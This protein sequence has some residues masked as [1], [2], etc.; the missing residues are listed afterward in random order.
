MGDLEGDTDGLEVG[1][2]DGVDV[3]VELE[4]ERVGSNVCPTIVGD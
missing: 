2:R 4:G 1:A 3:G